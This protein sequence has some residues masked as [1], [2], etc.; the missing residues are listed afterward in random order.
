M[1]SSNRRDRTLRKNRTRR[2]KRLNRP[3]K[4]K[5]VASAGYRGKR[6]SGKHDYLF[7]TAHPQRIVCE[8]P[9]VLSFSENTEETMEFFEGLRGGASKNRTIFI[10]LR[11]VLSVSVSEVIYL[12][13]C[14]EELE[15]QHLWGKVTGVTPVDPEAGR[16]FKASGFSKYVNGLHHVDS[17]DFVTVKTGQGAENT[18]A[19]DITR[20]VRRKLGV[21]LNETKGI[22]KI[23]IECMQ[24]TKDHA[25]TADT[26]RLGKWWLIAAHRPADNTVN[27]AFLDT[28]QGIP[29]TIHKR[30]I[31]NLD[32]VR[33]DVNLVLSGL[34]GEQRTRTKKH[35]RG[36][37]LPQVHT[38][39]ASGAGIASVFIVSRKAWVDCGTL[40]GQ[41][42]KVKFRG[43]LLMWSINGNKVAAS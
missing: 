34:R 10:D 25:Y 22:Y 7:H 37:G 15:H 13:A 2:R 20:F 1:S 19:Q 40:T 38:V 30:L 27:F 29:E 16:M 12:L 33:D 3:R 18:F 14:L 39:A 5:K 21:G 31:R 23:L 36:K 4:R 9:E 42:L 28:G 26:H 43:T 6:S 35:N 41:T 8:A 17:S 24:N 32:I 11:R